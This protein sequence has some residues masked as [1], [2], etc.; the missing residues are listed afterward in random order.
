PHPNED[1]RGDTSSV[2]SLDSED[3]VDLS[4]NDLIKWLSRYRQNSRAAEQAIAIQEEEHQ[5]ELEEHRQQAVQAAQDDPVIQLS[6]MISQLENKVDRLAL[7]KKSHPEQSD[8]SSNKRGHHDPSSSESANTSGD[9]HGSTDTASTPL[10]TLENSI[11]VIPVKQT[12]PNVVDPYTKWTS[13]VQT[14]LKS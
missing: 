13:R 8:P 9:S 6:H 5:K 4:K 10:S 14:L 11:P 7:K 3:L 12:A 1:D 2:H